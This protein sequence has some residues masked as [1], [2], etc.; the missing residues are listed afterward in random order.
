LAEVVVFLFLIVPSV[1]LSSFALRVVSFTFPV[2]AISTILQDTA[3]LL[4]VFFFIW[5]NDEPFS[6]V[7]WALGDGWKEVM[8]G[9]GLF[10]PMVF[11][12]Y[13]LEFLLRSAGLSVPEAP[14][15]YLTPSGTLEMALA[16]V[17]LV[18]VAAAEEV[19][20]RGYLLLRF[21]QLL[22]KPAAAV[23]LAAAVFSLGHGY[24]GT[25]GVLGVWVLGVIFGAVYL[26]RG[27]LVAPMVMHFL[28][29]FA[30]MVLVPLQKG[31]L[32]VF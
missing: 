12:I 6:A 32:G 14:P 26:W 2:V 7:G 5:R 30:G 28:Q 4:L 9:M 19:I 24:Q 18:V 22:Q 25:G 20:F 16:M 21:T 15:S 31:S 8:W 10:V 29:N 13:L 17:F 27:S 11:L 3:L 23:L 1:L